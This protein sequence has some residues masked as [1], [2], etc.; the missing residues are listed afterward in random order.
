MPKICQAGN[1]ETHSAS[2]RRSTASWCASTYLADRD[3]LTAYQCATQ[4]LRR[5]AIDLQD[6]EEALQGTL[7]GPTE[8]PDAA[9]AS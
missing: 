2:H 6:V 5:H 3:T 1:S 8:L 9:E 7:A 4:R